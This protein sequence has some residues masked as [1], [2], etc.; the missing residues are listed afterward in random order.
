M[1]EHLA[2]LEQGHQLKNIDL[3]KKALNFFKNELK[4]GYK[5]TE[6]ILRAYTIMTVIEPQNSLKYL[7]EAIWYDQ[8]NPIIL[9]NLAYTYHKDYNDVD[10]AI[11]LYEKC[12]EVSPPGFVIP[13][14]G[15]ID[16]AHQL[17]QSEVEY[18]YINKALEK[19]PNDADILN[20]KGIYLTDVMNDIP[21]ALACLKKAA[22]FSKNKDLNSKIFL[23]ISHLYSVT[24]KPKQAINYLVKSLR[25]DSKNIK[26]MQNILL[27]IHYFYDVKDLDILIDYFNVRPGSLTNVIENIHYKIAEIMFEVP[28]LKEI[29][30]GANFQPNFQNKIRIGYVSGDFVD[31]AVSHFIYPLLFEYSRDKFEVYIYSTR[32]HQNL[33]NILESATKYTYI[34][35]YYDYK[36]I[37]IIKSD[38]IDILIDLS[39]HTAHNKLSIFGTIDLKKFTYVGYPNITG[40]PGVQRISD[41]FTES[42]ESSTLKLPRLFLTYHPSFIPDLNLKS[43]VLSFGCFAKLSKI[44]DKLISIWCDIFSKVNR[45]FK[46]YLK[47]KFFKNKEI[48]DELLL[49]FGTFRKN[50]VL[51]MGTASQEEHLKKFGLL[52]IHFDTWPYSGTTISS[53]SLYTG[54]PIVTLCQE[55]DDHVSKVTGSIL[56]SMSLDHLIAKNTSEYIN[57]VLK[58]IDNLPSRKEIHDKFMSSE[59]TDYKGFIR[60]F[61]KLITN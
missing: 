39:G 23:N 3:V 18:T 20:I 10:R 57:I 5:T 49:K 22:K 11:K 28:N 34:E 21:E 55:S 7:N 37:E 6:N 41:E 8:N 24:G 1:N 30:K 14:L 33:K 58:L 13:F 29:S 46:F 35:N 27:N 9:N 36:I 44:N 31:H 56:H 16:I 19:C 40:I 26:A 50:V 2:L 25:E 45:P 51:L 60:E 32:L 48:C 12:I 17:S 4:N 43:D 61:E 54:V 38:K 59:I 53:E 52:D 15:I 42:K 47:S